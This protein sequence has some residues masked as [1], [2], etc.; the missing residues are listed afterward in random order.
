VKGNF[1]SEGNE[2]S[3]KGWFIDNRIYSDLGYGDHTVILLDALDVH[4]GACNLFI[5][6]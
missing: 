3:G 1:I 6:E 5:K 2:I 4:K